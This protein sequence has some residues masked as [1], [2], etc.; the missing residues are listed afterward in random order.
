M[1]EEAFRR[2]FYFATNFPE[3]IAQIKA[4]RQFKKWTIQEKYE[5]YDSIYKIIKKSYL[6]RFVSEEEQNKINDAAL[7]Q[8][9]ERGL[10]E[11]EKSLQ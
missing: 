1:D 4:S 6:S 8:I 5:V 2:E 9:I 3:Q 10:E 11:L 7:E